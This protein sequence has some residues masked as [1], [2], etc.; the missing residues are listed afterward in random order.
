MTPRDIE[1][2]VFRWHTSLHVDLTAGRIFPV[3]FVAGCAIASE[4][5]LA[6]YAD[7]FDNRETEICPTM[8][9]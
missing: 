6:Q 1:D 3:Q 9:F 8:S 5:A 2:I 4:W 7:L